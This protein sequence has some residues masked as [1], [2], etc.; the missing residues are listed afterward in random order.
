[1]TDCENRQGTV[2]S[3]PLAQEFYSREEL[4]R[5]IGQPWYEW[6]SHSEGTARHALDPWDEADVS[7][8]DGP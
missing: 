7:D 5:L 3:T 4:T 2:F 8:G 6:P 1:M